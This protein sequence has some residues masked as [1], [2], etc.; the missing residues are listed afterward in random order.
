MKTKILKFFIVPLL[1]LFCENAFSA[2]KIYWEDGFKI[3]HAS[4]YLYEK[5]FEDTEFFVI[6]IKNPYFKDFNVQIFSELVPFTKNKEGKHDSEVSKLLNKKKGTAIIFKD[7]II[8]CAIYDKKSKDFKT[9]SFRLENDEDS[10]KAYGENI[11]YYD[12]CVKNINAC[13]QTIETC[14]PLTIR[15]SRQVKVPYTVMEWEPG[16][17]GHSNF[18]ARNGISNSGTQI[19]RTVPVTK[20]RYETEY[21]DEINPNYNPQAVAEAKTNL[22]HWIIEKD[23]TQKKLVLP[24]R[25]YFD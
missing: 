24:Y 14:S 2:S 10:Y 21:Y 13:Y 12:K 11:S 5:D 1:I 7:G 8:K 16:S 17:I 4:L 6:N 3:I 18:T 19:G 15:K 25:L 20:Y 22:D 23:N 9:W